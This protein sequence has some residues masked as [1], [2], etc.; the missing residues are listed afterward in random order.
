MN[1]IP[2]MRYKNAP[3]AIEWLCRAFGFERYQ[4][5]EGEGD[6]ILHAQLKLGDSMIMLRSIRDLEYDKHLLHP[7]ETGGKTTQAMYV[8]VDD[9]ET[10]FEKACAAGAVIIQEIEEQGFGGKLYTCKGIEGYLWSFGTYNP[11]KA[12][13]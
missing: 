8:I 5:Y 10:H 1:I 6:I 13:N 7:S 11:W 4:V 3:L 12:E 2:T 9:L